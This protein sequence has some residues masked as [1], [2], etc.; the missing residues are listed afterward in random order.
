M[1]H[2]ANVMTGAG[3]AK[4]ESASTDSPES[5]PSAVCQQQQ[6]QQP[7]SSS[8]QPTSRVPD[9]RQPQVGALNFERR[10]SQIDIRVNLLT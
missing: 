2:A 1:N 4:E 7:L 3:W 5:S 9:Q 10:R 8:S 6:Q